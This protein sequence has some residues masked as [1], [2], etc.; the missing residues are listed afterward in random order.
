M[1]GLIDGL[2][3][4]ARTDG[5]VAELE[6]CDLTVIV[7][8]ELENMKEEIE[9]KDLRVQVGRLPAIRGIAFQYKQLFK[10]LFENAIKFSKKNNPAKIH[11]KAELLNDKEKKVFD[12]DGGKNI[13]GLTLVIMALDLTRIMQK[14][15][16]EP[17]VR[18]HPR[19]D[20]EGN[21]IGLSICKRIVINHKGRIFAEGN[22]NG[23][24]RF[25]LILPKPL[26][27]LKGNQIRIA[28]VDDDED[29]FFIIKEYI[30]EI[31]GANLLVD[32]LKDYRS[33][34]EK[35]R[36][37]AYELY[38]VDYRLGNETGLDLLQEAMAM[39]CDQPIV[40]LTGKGNRQ[41]ISRPCRAALLIT[42]RSR[43]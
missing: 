17:F 22:V 38:F 15:I 40:L 11:V 29:D 36:G 7:K 25:V 21:G 13:T 14:K 42:S 33:A 26:R 18:L 8:Q 30:Q 23:G 16:F 27:M 9:E 43:S 12:L 10:N 3:E 37:R 28:V 20:Y 19:S 34:L 35:I 31:Q 2:T 4:L 39:H 32:W 6:L 5:E 41:L 1:K 24:S